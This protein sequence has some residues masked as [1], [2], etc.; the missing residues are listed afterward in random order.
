MGTCYYFVR[1]DTGTLFDFD[2]AYGLTTWLETAGAIDDKGLVVKWGLIDEALEAW[3]VEG[4][5]EDEEFDK[6]ATH[7]KA[8]ELA[9]AVREFAGYGPP[10]CTFQPVY[11]V[12]EH[13]VVIDD[14]ID[15][16]GSRVDRITYDRF[17]PGYKLPACEK[18]GTPTSNRWCTDCI[19]GDT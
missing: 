14:I 13:A 2:K 15:K 6:V 10:H 12:S 3:L 4:R 19:A 11:F 9:D 1:P 17:A 18:C 8:V 7:K 16:H 5:R